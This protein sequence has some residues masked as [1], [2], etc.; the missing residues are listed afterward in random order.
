M[1]VG[2]AIGDLLHADG[3]RAQ[4]RAAELV[5]APGGLLLRDA[6]L[7]GGL[8]GRVLA[9]AGGRI[10]P[11]MTSSTSPATPSRVQGG[12]DRDGAEF[13][14]RQR[15]KA[16]LKEP[17]AV[18]AALTIDDV[19]GHGLFLRCCG[20]DAAVQWPVCALGSD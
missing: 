2:I 10:W 12:L 16:P 1:T 17:T 13:V 9:L 14:G 7:D 5:E 8:A 20:R 18:R 11:R 3:D 19:G 6:G 15:R 4:A